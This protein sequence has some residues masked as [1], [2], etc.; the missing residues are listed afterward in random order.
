MKTEPPTE[1]TCRHRCTNKQTCAH[2]CCKGTSV[3]KRKGSTKSKTLNSTPVLVALS[4][5]QNSSPHFPPLSPSS[6]QPDSPSSKTSEKKLTNLRLNTP[7][8]PTFSSQYALPRPSPPSMLHKEKTPHAELEPSVLNF[9]DATPSSP[10]SPSS[11]SSPT[12]FD[13]QHSYEGFTADG[14][15]FILP[16]TYDTIESFIRPNIASSLA[17]L[18]CLFWIWLAVFG[19]LPEMFH[20]QMWFFWRCCYNVGLGTTLH[21]QSN[22]KTITRFYEKHT[23]RNTCLSR[24]LKRLAKAGVKDPSYNPDKYPACFNAWLVHKHLVNLILINDSCNYMLLGY[25]C[26]SI[27]DH[28]SYAVIA[29]YALGVSLM[30][31]NY[32]AKVDA[33]RCIGEY[34]WYWGDF[35]YAKNVQLTFDGIFEL[36]PHPMYTVG[37]SLYY[38][39]TLIVRSYTMFFVSLAAHLMQL[40]FLVAVEEPH[41]ERTYGGGSHSDSMDANRFRALYD[42]KS[43]YFPSRKDSIMFSRL[44]VFRDGDFAVVTLTLYCFAVCYLVPS[45]EWCLVQG[46]AWRLLQWVVLGFVLWGQSKYQFWTRHHMAKGRSLHEAFSNWKRLYNLVM[47]VNVAAFIGC[48][49]RYFDWA[50]KPSWQE[51][52]MDPWCMTTLSAGTVLIL[53]SVWST[54]SMYETVGDFGWF[55]GDFFIHVDAF[56]QHLCYTGVYRFLN[57]PDCVTGYAGLYGV[58]LICQ[59]WPVFG[60][61]VLAHI[62]NILFLNLVEVPHME[63]L[64]NERGK[65]RDPPIVRKI[66]EN[67]KKIVPLS[68]NMKNKLKE[69]KVNQEKLRTNVKDEINTIRRKALNDMFGVYKKLKKDQTTPQSKTPSQAAAPKVEA[70]TH[71]T[72]GQPLQVHYTTDG[73][74]SMFDWIGIYPFDVPSEPGLS[75]GKWMF[76]DE[77]ENGNI[78]FPPNLQPVHEGVYEIRYHPDNTYNCLS[79]TPVIFERK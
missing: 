61:S 28:F 71:H 42:P 64:Y 21:F 54:Y 14:T 40:T 23:A 5:S 37:Y 41:I 13:T 79:S 30:L 35:F 16:E 18:L 10:T 56:E 36:F 6:S 47:T 49:V 77:K 65:R 3:V 31:F 32:W 22:Y 76:V 44:D 58:S 34:C 43:G 8:S 33:H 1:N 69:A 19:N 66:V 20:I 26:L 72:I 52:V 63:K 2:A 68:E 4:P 38:G 50:G 75:A 9:G 53:L 74:H 46:V 24:L 55:Y 67:I 60:L 78:T 51:Y 59:S 48:A 70:P 29:Q 27:P 57:N 15:K 12:K 7:P 39:Y 17:I 73:A 45:P 25:K 62:L 11:A